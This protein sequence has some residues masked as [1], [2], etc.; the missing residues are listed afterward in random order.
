MFKT[1]TNKLAQM[2]KWQCKF[3]TPNGLNIK[4]VEKTRQTDQINRYIYYTIGEHARWQNT[5]KA[6]SWHQGYFSGIRPE[7]T[8]WLRHLRGHR[9]MNNS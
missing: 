7:N 8:P 6:P 2:Q 1:E 4:I 3:E 9:I 5:L